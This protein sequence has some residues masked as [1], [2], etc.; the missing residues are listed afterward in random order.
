M[1]KFLSLVL[2]LFLFGCGEKP[3]NVIR[4]LHLDV[5]LVSE[6]KTIEPGETFWVGLRLDMEEGWHVNWVNPGDAGLAP[7]ISWELPEG[8]TAGEIEWPTPM[9]LPI[10]PFMLFGYED[11]VLLPVKITPPEKMKSGGA[12]KLLAYADWVVCNEAC[13]P[14]KATLNLELKIKNDAPES[15]EMWA[16]SFEVTRKNLPVENGD[17]IFNAEITEY[18][19]YIK[20]T[21][22]KDNNPTFD[23]MLFFPQ[24]Q[25]IIN[26][27]ADQVLT[28]EGN[29]YK[30]EI[31]RDRMGNSIPEILNGVLVVERQLPEG[32][33][34][35]GIKLNLPLKRIKS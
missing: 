31:H 34:Q 10:S 4:S 17:W 8:F 35:K 2:V 14:G 25:G 27:A 29:G 12:V 7:K 1:R 20:L 9:R 19:V 16:A 22:L 11:D 6:I 28:K 18:R 21:S 13:I 24:Q 5:E 33:E 30:L 23:R 15:N 26:N 32:K 3:S